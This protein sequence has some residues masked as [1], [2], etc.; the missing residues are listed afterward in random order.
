MIRTDEAVSRFLSE[1][2]GT[3]FVPPYTVMG[4]ERNGEIVAGV[5]FN[6]FEHPDVH[7]T[8]AGSGWT[9]GFL[10][11]VGRY[12]FGQ[13]GCLRMTATTEQT[14]VASLAEK[15]GGQREGVLRDHFGEGRDGVI[16]GILRR[17]WKWANL[18]AD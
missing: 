7:F 16:I 15:L 11:E 5:L 4:L 14:H 6:C 18:P 8:A 10:R 13:L 9:R 3:V 12:V 17:E 1:K 2:L